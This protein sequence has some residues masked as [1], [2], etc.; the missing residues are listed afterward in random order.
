M[1]CCTAFRWPKR[2]QGHVQVIT[3]TVA[4]L[5]T[6]QR[7]TSSDWKH[8]RVV[9]IDVQCTPGSAFEDIIRQ[10]E[11]PSLP[12]FKLIDLVRTLPSC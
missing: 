8:K 12:T 5:S 7:G 6:S 10:L 3:E 2:W 11:N 9:Q 1:A 4:T